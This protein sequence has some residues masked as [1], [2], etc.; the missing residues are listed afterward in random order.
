M[1]QIIIFLFSLVF[2][3]TACN[4][5]ESQPA[6]QSHPL[7]NSSVH[8]NSASDINTNADNATVCSDL[9]EEF[10]ES[11][12][13]DGLPTVTDYFETHDSAGFIVIPTNHK[14]TTVYPK[15]EDFDSDQKGDTLYEKAFNEAN[16]LT[17]MEVTELTKCLYYRASSLE[18]DVEVFTLTPWLSIYFPSQE[19]AMEFS[20]YKDVHSLE[21][22]QNNL[23]K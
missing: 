14:L 17:M 4:T 12:F 16:R 9:K 2:I 10:N 18:Y 21:L 6:K 11:K 3:T 7:S 15:R 13:L 22:I 5:E 20:K 8:L 23:L 1:K 19:A